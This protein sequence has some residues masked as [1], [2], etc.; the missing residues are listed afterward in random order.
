M[1]PSFSITEKVYPF[2]GCG[3][4]PREDFLLHVSFIPHISRHVE[5]T[6][7][8]ES[9]PFLTCKKKHLSSKKRKIYLQTDDPH[10]FLAFISMNPATLY[11]YRKRSTKYNLLVL[12][13]KNLKWTRPPTFEF[14]SSV[15]MGSD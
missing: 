4:Y 8:L 15:L 12:I 7:L 9:N 13:D 11:S 6:S 1:R 2:F 5:F 14:F 3:W 10:I